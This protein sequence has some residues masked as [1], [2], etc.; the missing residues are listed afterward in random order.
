[1]EEM[2]VRKEKVERDAGWN[3]QNLLGGM[4]GRGWEMAGL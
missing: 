4:R 2:Q 1:M 3:I